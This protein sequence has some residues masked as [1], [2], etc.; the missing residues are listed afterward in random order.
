MSKTRIRIDRTV[1][2]SSTEA[3]VWLY[4]KD[5]YGGHAAEMALSAAVQLYRMHLCDDPD[6]QERIRQ[7]SLSFFIS[8]LP[9]LSSVS[10]PPELNVP[11]P[12]VSDVDQI[13]EF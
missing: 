10:I 8:L 3:Q 9:S 2:N 5:E 12:K 4:L 11:E 7:K 1:E 13:E 6:E